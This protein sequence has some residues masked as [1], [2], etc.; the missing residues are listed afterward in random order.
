[1]TFHYA[2][3]PTTLLLWA[4][5]TTGSIWAPIGDNLDR[6]N[7]IAQQGG[8]ANDAINTKPAPSLPR[9]QKMSAIYPPKTGTQYQRQTCEPRAAEPTIGPLHCGAPQD[10]SRRSTG[11]TDE[12][13]ISFQIFNGDN[14]NQLVI[15]ATSQ[16][17]YSILDEDSKNYLKDHPYC[18]FAIMYDV[19]NEAVSGLAQTTTPTM[20]YTPYPSDIFPTIYTYVFHSLPTQLQS[21]YSLATVSPTLTATWCSTGT[22][23]FWAGYQQKA[24]QTDAPS[25]TSTSA[26]AS[27][28]SNA[29]LPSVAARHVGSVDVAL[30][31]M[32]VMLASFVGGLVWL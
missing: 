10:H 29:A 9:P 13:T 30:I 26:M 21:A 18:Y 22:T 14:V 27:T 25:S 28:T 5:L 4:Q 17:F 20:S 6:A 19:Y 23:S 7:F 11:D 12:D 16:P 3:V 8:N 24:V 31:M 15:Q 32:A 2:L 1:M